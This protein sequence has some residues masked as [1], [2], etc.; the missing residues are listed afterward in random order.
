MMNIDE[1]GDREEKKLLRR[2]T[3]KYL[4]IKIEDRSL[5]E[6]LFADEDTRVKTGGRGEWCYEKKREAV[7]SCPEQ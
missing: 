5:G 6:W 1:E 4:R 3:S 2:L 7:S